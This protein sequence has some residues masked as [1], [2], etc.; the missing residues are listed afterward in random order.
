MTKLARTSCL[1]AA[2]T[3]I[4]AA[5]AATTARMISVERQLLLKR[6]LMMGEKSLVATLESNRARWEKLDP[7]RQEELRRQ[8]YA[9]RSADIEE[10]RRILEAWEKFVAL[11]EARQNDYRRRAA[12]LKSVID[13]LNDQQKREL[14]EMT[15]LDRA[16]E[17][18]RVRRQLIS[19]G[20]LP[21]ARAP[22]D[23]AD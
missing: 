16:R 23:P 22:G 19:E 9:F 4:V 21:P 20:N 17:L 12:W 5:G 6:K 14:L 11:D 10:Q 7:T 2:L 3:M 13:T 15:P 1:A 8:A 18:L